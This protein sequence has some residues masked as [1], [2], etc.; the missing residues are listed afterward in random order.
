MKNLSGWRVVGIGILLLACAP[1]PEKKKTTSQPGAAGSTIDITDPSGAAGVAP[2]TETG[3][4]GD[5]ST[6]AAGSD[7]SGAAGA[8]P[9]GAAGVGSGSAGN[10]GAAGTSGAAGAN[11][12]GGT[13]GAVGKPGAAGTTGA[14]GQSGAAGKPGTAGTTG[15]AG[16]NG[17]AGTTGAAGAPAPPTDPCARGAWTFTPS[18]VCTVNCNTMID[19]T[20]LPSNAI[21]GNQA[22]RYTTGIDQGINGPETVVLSFPKTVSLAGITLYAKDKTDFPVGYLV[23]HSA[24]GTTFVPFTPSLAGAGMQTMSIMFPMATPLRAVRITQTGKGTYWWSISE[25]GV[26]D[27]KVVP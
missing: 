8:D 7:P 19:A 10:G 26:L 1:P 25:L 17:A 6:G 21:D 3:A 15:A 5:G 14:A 13:S 11:G 16:A 20:K 9:T 27:C 12:A 4:A 18:V 24:D 2:P 22:T 23:E